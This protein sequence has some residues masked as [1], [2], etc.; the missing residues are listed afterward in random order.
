MASH[1]ALPR[2]FGLVHPKYQTPSVPIWRFGL[3][4]LA[5]S[6]PL[7][8]WCDNVPSDAVGLTIAIEWAKADAGETTV[9]G[10]AWCRS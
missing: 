8:I 2:A 10:S 3:V 1:G 5:L 4:S 6:V 7:A 9:F